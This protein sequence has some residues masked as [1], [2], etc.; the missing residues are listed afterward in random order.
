MGG[1]KS[2][3]VHLMSDKVVWCVPYAMETDCPFILSS[4]LWRVDV[5]LTM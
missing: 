1:A 4:R 3:Q 2:P 5:F